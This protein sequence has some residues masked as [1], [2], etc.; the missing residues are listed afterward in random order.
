MRF[1]AGIQKNLRLS[2]EGV[3]RAAAMQ[4]GRTTLMDA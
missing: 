2:N 3:E 1:L 4:I